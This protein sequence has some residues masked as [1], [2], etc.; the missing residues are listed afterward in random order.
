MMLF[1]ELATED[2]LYSSFQLPLFPFELI[3][4]LLAIILPVSVYVGYR[5]G[6]AIYLQNEMATDAPAHDYGGTSLGAMLALLGLLLAF[7]F[8][9]A[10]NWADARNRALV[11]DAATIG[12]AFLRADIL[13]EP[14]RSKLRNALLDYARTR[15][16]PKGSLQTKADL[17]AFFSETLD[18]QATLWPVAIEAVGG[19][20]PPPIQ[21]F[22]LGSVNDVLDAHTH[23]FR[24]GSE[25]LPT[26]IKLMLLSAA[27]LALIFVGNRSAIQGRQLTWR[28]FALSGLLSVVMIVILDLD[29]PREG[30]ITINSDAIRATIS[31][32]ELSV[33]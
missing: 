31:E 14:G 17:R 21:T 30:L 26:V 25:A 28:T 10:L 29:R 9:S 12:T 20:T 6:R 8:G 2:Q 32:L 23:R 27:I 18:K 19:E 3:V 33:G 22:I 7:S 11:D 13:S 1:M 16:I 5:L 15:Y 4:L 24:T